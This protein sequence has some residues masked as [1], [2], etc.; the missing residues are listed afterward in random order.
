MEFSNQPVWP[1]WWALSR[2]GSCLK[3]GRQRSWG[4][5]LS[6]S[7]GLQVHALTHDIHTKTITHICT[8]I[9]T[10]MNHKNGGYSRRAIRRWGRMW[11]W[12]GSWE[13]SAVAASQGEQR[14]SGIWLKPEEAG[15]PLPWSRCHDSRLLL[16]GTMWTKHCWYKSPKGGNVLWGEGMLRN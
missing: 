14:V 5:C 7:S 10:N 13:F 4:W 2:E 12:Q 1:N 8:H 15:R 11:C 3:G 16:S 6:L 9:Y